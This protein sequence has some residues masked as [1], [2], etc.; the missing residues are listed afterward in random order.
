MRFKAL[1][2]FLCFFL[3]CDLKLICFLPSR[4][5]F[6]KDKKDK[7]TRGTEEAEKILERHPDWNREF[8]AQLE[9][10]RKNGVR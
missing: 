3:Q 7:E 8:L 9:E 5:Y 6:Y 1:S 10:G 2:V 4:Y